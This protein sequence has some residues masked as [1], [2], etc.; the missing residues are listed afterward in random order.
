MS[1][2]TDN[3]AAE[4]LYG[5]AHIRALDSDREAWCGANI[6]MTFALLDEA[7]A[8]ACIATGTRLQPCEKCMRELEAWRLIVL[9]ED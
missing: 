5:V 9:G 7:H 1:H 4:L 8:L 2:R 3:A 6:Y